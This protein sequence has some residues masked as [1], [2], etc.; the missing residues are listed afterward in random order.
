MLLQ[1]A[2][3]CNKFFSWFI[4]LPSRFVE[5]SFCQLYP[6]NATDDKNKNI[7]IHDWRI[8]NTFQTRWIH[9]ENLSLLELSSYIKVKA[10]SLSMQLLM[11]YIENNDGKKISG[12]LYHIQAYL[13]W[14]LRCTK[15]FFAE[16]DF[17]YH[18]TQVNRLSKR[19][20][21]YLY[22]SIEL[23][24]THLF[25]YCKRCKLYST[26]LIAFLSREQQP[27][28]TKACSPTVQ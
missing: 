2:T 5:W 8:T 15:I 22:I 7:T 14:S 24:L 21:A 27:C 12:P 28:L 18:Y 20:A 25:F 10:H 6:L 9:A 23:T 26:A 11:M 4:T 17:V 19:N 16:V 3:F 13:R 1:E